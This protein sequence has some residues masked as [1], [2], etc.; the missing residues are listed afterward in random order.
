MPLPQN[1]ITVTTV[2]PHPIYHPQGNYHG[3]HCITTFPILLCHPLVLHLWA[4]IIKG[5]FLQEFSANSMPLIHKS[6][7]QFYAASIRPLI[8]SS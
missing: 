3:N 8:G 7:Y 1:V 2:L 6:C 5:L 4:D